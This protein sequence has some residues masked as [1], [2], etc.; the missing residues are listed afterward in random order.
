MNQPTR[1]TAEEQPANALMAMFV[2][3]FRS[4]CR[5]AGSIS[6]WQQQR[7]QRR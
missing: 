4:W 6:G 5:P 2:W 3:W 7:Q 1:R